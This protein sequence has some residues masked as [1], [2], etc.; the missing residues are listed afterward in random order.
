M[1]ILGAGKLTQRL[2]ALTVLAGPMSA[3]HNSSFQESYASGSC[4]HLHRPP[5]YKHN[6]KKILKPGVVV[7]AFTSSTQQAKAGGYLTSK[8]A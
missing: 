1:T 7:H 3:A 5:P 4:A 8:P 6:F 2:R